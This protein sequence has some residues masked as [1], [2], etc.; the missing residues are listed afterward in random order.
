MIRVAD[1]DIF[2]LSDLVFDFQSDETNSYAISASN[3]EETSES[4]IGID[5]KQSLYSR[6]NVVMQKEVTYI[7]AN[8]YANMLIDKE[9]LDSDWTENEIEFEPV[10]RKRT[11]KDFPA[12]QFGYLN[13]SDHSDFITASSVTD[14]TIKLAIALLSTAAGSST[15]PNYSMSPG[16]TTAISEIRIQ[17][18]NLV[19]T[20]GVSL[21]ANFQ[22]FQDEA[23]RKQI[24]ELTDKC[25]NCGFVNWIL[26][27]KDL[28]GGRLDLRDKKGENRPN[29]EK[30]SFA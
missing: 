4:D 27:S 9:C 20:P 28:C 29:T 24:S 11:P 3:E 14:H 7:G 22:F 13:R 19:T 12:F 30:T 15:D 18:N 5:P 26:N 25:A 8:K 17:S 21:P 16:R 23:A 6:V 2:R 1:V 10:H